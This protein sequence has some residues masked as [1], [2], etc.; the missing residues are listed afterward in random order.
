[1]PSIVHAQR[2]D[3]VQPLASKGSKNHRLPKCR[4]K[5]NHSGKDLVACGECDHGIDV[6]GAFSGFCSGLAEANL[7]TEK[8]V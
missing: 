7:N 8:L 5:P 2:E 1:M 6:C 4:S 3:A